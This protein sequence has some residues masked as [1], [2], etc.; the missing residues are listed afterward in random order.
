MSRK[1]EE[2]TVT[3]PAPAA[4]ILKNQ[5]KVG[6]ENPVGPGAV[7]NDFKFSAKVSSVCST[8]SVGGSMDSMPSFD[9]TDMEILEF[10]QPMET[11]SEKKPVFNPVVSASNPSSC[12][13][14]VGW[15]H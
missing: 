4:T 2:R 10:D 14:W 8:T 1:L 12:A 11:L 5:V 15:M 9:L 3:V 6:F 7:K 13:C